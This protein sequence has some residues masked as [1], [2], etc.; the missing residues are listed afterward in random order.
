M[1]VRIGEV[2]DEVNAQGVP[3]LL[4]EQNAAMALAISSSAYVLD[5]GEVSLG[6]RRRPP[7]T[8]TRSAGST[9]GRATPPPRARLRL[10]STG[11]RPRPTA[12]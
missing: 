4:V 1:V 6:Q 3:V 5:V 10:D 11:T 2:V 12:P 9:S 7:R 8:A